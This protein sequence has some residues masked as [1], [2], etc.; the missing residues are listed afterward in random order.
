MSRLDRTREVARWAWLL[1]LVAAAGGRPSAAAEVAIVKSS[2]VPAWRPA[3]DALRR[4]AAGHTLTEFDLRN[5]RGVA[6]SVLS[7]LKTRNPVVVAMGPLAAQLVRTNLPDAPMV[8][9]MVQDPA[10]MGLAA[11]QGVTGVAFT[12]PIKNQI[13][14]FRLVNPRGVRIG[15]IYK[16]DNSGRQVEEAVKAGGLLRVALIP[17]AV[18]SE[19]EIPAALRA[20]LAGDEAIDALWIPTDPVLL[21]DETRKFLLSEMFKAGRAVYGSTSGL[22]AEGALVSNGPDLV[23]IGEQV[24]ELV[25]RLAAGDRTR[26][27]LLVPRAELVIN[28]KIAGRLKIDLPA[29]VLKTA[30]KVY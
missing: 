9:A 10:K 21:G 28:K 5:D 30:N 17:R 7:S 27:D 13:A 15:V 20:L 1:G 29:D 25:N 2:E 6:D 19:R 8:F 22:V 3:I 11:A 23:S 14:A 18:A 12:I 26:I 4:V 24:G 16:E